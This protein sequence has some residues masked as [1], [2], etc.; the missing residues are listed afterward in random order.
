[1]HGQATATT[2][3]EILLL[4]DD[5]V[6]ALSRQETDAA[7]QM[8]RR[9]ADATDGPGLPGPNWA[10]VGTAARVVGDLLRAEDAELHLSRRRR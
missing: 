1:M 6:A 10:Q 8:C 4:A 5:L 7:A 3:Q 9:I 2:P